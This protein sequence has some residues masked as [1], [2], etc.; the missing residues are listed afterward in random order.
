MNNI[1]EE[2][3]GDQ[4]IELN[5]DFHELSAETDSE[6]EQEPA[7]PQTSGYPWGERHRPMMLTYG[8]LGK[9]TMVDVAVRELQES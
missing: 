2:E 3:D 7:A 6:E 5:L 9:L 1:Q 4:A 8:V